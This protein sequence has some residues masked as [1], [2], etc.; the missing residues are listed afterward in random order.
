MVISPNCFYHVFQPESDVSSKYSFNSCD[1]INFNGTCIKY[2]TEYATTSYSPPFTYSYQCGSEFITYYVPVFV[3]LC[4]LSTF[5]IP[6]I[7]FIWIMMINQPNNFIMNFG[8]P[9]L[10]ST[11]KKII[12]VNDL[13]V[14]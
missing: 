13:F 14:N 4:M 2:Q 12:N 6:I 1:I 9:T 7:Q 10:D 8:Q 11:V 5:I 3:L